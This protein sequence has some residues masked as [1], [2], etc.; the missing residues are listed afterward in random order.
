MVSNSRFA[1]KNHMVFKSPNKM[2]KVMVSPKACMKINRRKPQAQFWLFC[3]V[4]TV[5]CFLL[6][7]GN[8]VAWSSAQLTPDLCMFRMPGSESTKQ[9]FSLLC[10]QAQTQ[11]EEWLSQTGCHQVSFHPVYECTQINRWRDL[12]TLL[13][14]FWTLDFNM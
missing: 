12:S 13:F 8:S 6:Q 1:L 2:E 5:I 9:P 14:L 3:A 4:C 10:E 11:A 7:E